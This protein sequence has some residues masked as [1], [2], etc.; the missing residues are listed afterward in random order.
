MEKIICNPLNLEYHFQLQKPDGKWT[1]SREG[2]DPTVI[3][4]RDLYLLFVSMSGGFWY[5][6]DLINWKF[7]ETPELPIYDYAP[8]VHEVDGKVIWSGSNFSKTML[9]YSEDPVN[10]PFKPLPH[11][12]GKWWD[13]AIFQDDDGRV[14]FYH[15]SSTEPITGVELDRN[16]WKPLGKFIPLAGSDSKNRGWERVGH[17]NL[18]D[19]VQKPKTLKDKWFSLF[20][21]EGAYVE[22]AFMTKHGGK[23]YLQYAAPGTQFNV[24]SDGVYVSE[25]PLGPFTYQTHNP[26]SSVPGGFITAAGH[27]S[28][29]RDKKGNW[30]HASTM[31]IGV[32]DKFER[33]V[34]FF[35]CS[36]DKDGVMHCDQALADYPVELSSGQKT[37]WMLLN[38]SMSA[39]SAQPGYEAEK[40]NDENIQTWWAAED[41]DAA[42]WLQMDLG[43]AK[44]V[45]AVQVNFAEHQVPLPQNP[46]DLVRKTLLGARKIYTQI[47]HTGYLLEG[48]ADGSIW[49]VLRCR[50]SGDFTHDLVCLETPRHLRYLRLRNM[51]LAFNAV[52]AVSGLRVFGFGNGR[53]P[54]Q[55]SSI[56]F[57]QEGALNIQIQWDPAK[58]ATRYNVRYGIDPNKL[59]N[60]WQ[61]AEN[62]LDLSFIN[63][64]EVYFAAV[65]AINENGITPGN[66][67]RLQSE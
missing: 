38:G 39:S 25:S 16:T 48:S 51:K 67:V 41:T 19:S 35:P 12:A 26:F 42:Q 40:A 60:S 33:R 43:E 62:M 63:K 3:L 15:G 28:T 57:R 50:S 13:P 6:D 49:E 52:P 56:R 10:E 61:I 47:Q 34:G 46:N 7:R 55:V 64:G 11:T 27:G 21:K 2:A 8:D 36:F 45:Y 65:D 17:N 53:K 23:Y 31:L 4:W 44:M 66:I 9:Y 18:P 37:G 5:S 54:E 22:G 30:W 20:A 59:Y 29:F 1:L 58:G 32:N 14:Y 24:Y